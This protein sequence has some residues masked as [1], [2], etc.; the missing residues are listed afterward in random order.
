MVE[1]VVNKLS[2]NGKAPK[3][4]KIKES[5]SQDKSSEPNKYWKQEIYNLVEEED[6]NVVNCLKKTH[7][8]SAFN[9]V[10]EV[11]EEEDTREKVDY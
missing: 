1:C 6:R 7:C 4:Y 10:E 9:Y 2:T 11:E 8:C 5:Y 3:A